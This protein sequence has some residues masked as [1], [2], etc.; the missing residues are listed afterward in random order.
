MWLV[1]VSVML[2]VVQWASSAGGSPRLPA[3]RTPPRFGTSAAPAATAIA[4]TVASDRT[5]SIR[6]VARV[7]IFID[8]LVIAMS[9]VNLPDSR[10]AALAGP[11]SQAGAV[12]AEATGPL[13]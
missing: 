9:S 8:L 5:V 12:V 13:S 7:D 10:E 4:N 1:S 11:R 6:V 2:A 3:R